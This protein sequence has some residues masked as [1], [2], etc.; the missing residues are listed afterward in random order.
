PPAAAL[1]E[2]VEPGPLLLGPVEV[3][4]ARQPRLYGGLDEDEAEGVGI[5]RVLDAQRPADAV[6][7]VGPAGVVLG[8]LEVGQDALVVPARAA[9]LGPAV[10]VRPVAADVDHGVDGG[11]AAEDLPAGP[12]QR[13]PGE[14]RLRLG[15]VGPVHLRLE[16]PAE[17]GGDLDLGAGV[18]P[19]RFEEEDARGG[20]GAEA[21]G[22]HAP[23]RAGTD[24]D[25]VVHGGPRAVA[26]VP[27]RP[28]RSPFRAT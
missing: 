12:E 6:V 16:Q 27:R 1:V 7:G 25:V 24:D 21:V 4:V 23:R 10:V 20:V 8:A 13:A 28:R 14:A 9:G 22:Q 11:G 15:V 19:A 3:G 5:A 26:S 18:R 17:G 2:L